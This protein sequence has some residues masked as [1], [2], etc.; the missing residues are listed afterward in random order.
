MPSLPPL[1]GA[2]PDAPAPAHPHAATPDP[3][4]SGA[5]TSG[6]VG[7]GS[8]GS[9]SAGSDSGVFD[10]A[11]GD[12][13]LLAAR[14][15]PPC[16]RRQAFRALLRATRDDWD[17]RGHRVT[18]LAA[19]PGTAALAREWL[20]ADPRSADAATLH[21]HALV[22]H[23]LDG[24]GD[25]GAA[26]TACRAAAALAPADPTPWL[27]LLL[28][29]RTLGSRHAT[30][31]VFTEIRAR[32]PEHHHAHHLYIARLAEAPEDRTALPEP[33]DHREPYGA[34]PVYAV[35]GKAALSAPA[36][37]PL[38]LLPVV[39]HAE[40]FRVLA[41]TG[42]APADPDAVAH[43]AGP[44]ARQALS[45][46]FDWW[47]EWEH[48]DHPRRHVDLNHLAHAMCAA[49]RPAEAAVLFRRIGRHATRAP[50]SHPHQDP[51]PAFHAAR[52][53]A[54]GTS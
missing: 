21:A 6:S 43:W 3:A 40:R 37:S 8:A 51:A 45:T 44:R 50:W 41:A 35:A 4:G 48:G 20:T 52:G 12:T 25:P 17:R 18:V 23:A 38:A 30:H 47:L 33:D 9:G 2:H 10:D 53:R 22:R 46:A 15:E 11:L 19:Q 32:H 27:G 1:L 14:A 31:R 26:R 54:L 49:G 16:G 5:A 42:R 36:D 34:H 7:S 39:A 29:A 24:T 13:A 28:L